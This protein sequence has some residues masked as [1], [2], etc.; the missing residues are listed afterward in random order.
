MWGNRSLAPHGETREQWRLHHSMIYGVAPHG[1]KEKGGN[2]MES[3]KIAPPDDIRPI[4]ALL[5]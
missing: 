2:T 4:I 1:I 5:T 3:K